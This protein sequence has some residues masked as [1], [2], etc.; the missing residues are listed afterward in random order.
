[1]TPSKPFPCDLSKLTTCAQTL[2]SKEA[3][4]DY[5][6]NSFS[7]SSSECHQ[8]F[9]QHQSFYERTIAHS[10]TPG[11]LDQFITNVAFVYSHNQNYD[12]S[13]SSNISHHVTLNQFSD[14]F[15]HELPYFNSQEQWST[16]QREEILYN[17]VTNTQNMNNC[18]RCEEHDKFVLNLI[19]ENSPTT[20]KVFYMR[21]HKH[22]DPKALVVHDTNHGTRTYKGQYYIL[23]TS[24]NT[25][26]R[27][28]NPEIFL[29]DF[30]KRDDNWGKSLNWATEEN[31]D[32]VGIVHPAID[33][34]RVYITRAYNVLK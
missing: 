21:R 3:S 26:Y 8:L 9:L 10:Q 14:M 28:N 16:S 11:R 27:Y 31:P 20:S 23:D 33:Q 19:D 25:K 4:N 22:H 17:D 13:S 18:T 15:D 34:V 6:T 12:S 30:I 2:L 32:G 24:N 7:S 29:Y 5:S 1:M